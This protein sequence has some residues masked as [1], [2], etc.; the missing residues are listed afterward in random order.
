MKVKILS[1][2][3]LILSI[4]LNAQNGISVGNGNPDERYNLGK[5]LINTA[6]NGNL[7]RVK[8]LV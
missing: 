5:E 7:E 1:L 2:I 3:L 8:Y 6:K 4:S